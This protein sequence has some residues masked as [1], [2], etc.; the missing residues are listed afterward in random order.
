MLRKL[1]FFNKKDI[2]SPHHTRKITVAG[3][4]PLCGDR[5]DKLYDRFMWFSY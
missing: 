4:K 3:R 2:I 5:N 1:Q